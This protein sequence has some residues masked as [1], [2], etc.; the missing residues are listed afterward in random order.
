MVE[1]YRKAG[2]S[3]SQPS[4][5]GE[6]SR[7]RPVN[8]EMT[9]SAFGIAANPTGITEKWIDGPAQSLQLR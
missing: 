1:L 6:G 4:H 5:D 7:P 9:N 3:R 8:D 2:E